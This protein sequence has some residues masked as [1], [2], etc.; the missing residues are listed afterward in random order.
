MTRL[1]ISDAAAEDIERL[2]DF[3]MAHL[4]HE[5]VRTVDVILDGLEILKV[6]P[7]V[8]RPRETGMR[9]LVISRGRS[10]YLAL[11]AYDAEADLVVVL[12]LRHQRES[13]Y[14]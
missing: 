3:L 6:H 12:S 1:A 9:E 11:Y 13:G 10:G 2:A 8:G 7:E 5:A 4:P 14:H